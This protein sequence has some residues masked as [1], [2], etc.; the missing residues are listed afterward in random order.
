MRKTI[1]G[2]K[3]SC[4]RESFEKRLNCQV[5]TEIY[6]AAYIISLAYCE[7]ITAPSIYTYEGQLIPRVFGFPKNLP[8]ITLCILLQYK[9]KNAKKKKKIPINNLFQY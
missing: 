5:W 7:T 9:H 2:R 6:I 3:I 4:H 1:K 8:K